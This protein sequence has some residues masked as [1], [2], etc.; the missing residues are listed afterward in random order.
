M[1]G[2]EFI[3]SAPAQRGEVT[4]KWALGRTLRYRAMRV[5]TPDGLNIA[6]QDWA[7]D[8]ARRKAE[9]LLLHGF[10]QSHG[11]WFHQVTGPLAREFR[12]VT[13]DLRGHGESDKPVDP[14]HYRT[15][16][17]WA[18]ELQAV[19]DAS[20]LQRPILVAWSYSGRVAL[21]YLSL[22][23]D[24]GLAGL[25][26]V[27]SSSNGDPAMMGPAASMLRQMTNLDSATAL[28]G[29]LALLRAC[30]T[31]PLLPDE[32]DYMLRYNQLVPP[33]IRINLAGRPAE[34]QTVLRAVRIPTLVMQG[35]LDPVTAPAMSAYTAEHVRDARAITYDG[36]AHM[37]FW[38]SPQRFDDDLAQF[39]NQRILRDRK[40]KQN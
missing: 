6:V 10:S 3:H 16:A 4:E 12:L 24:A 29:T 28:A 25:V 9:L 26:M 22:F 7:P 38:E 8:G 2:Y 23:G 17:L 14:H 39:V 36:L 33:A 19:I 27:N 5:A 11:A 31:K 21:D 13:Y 15:G 34:Y 20:A 32:L 30:V 35:S 37:P 40:T 1:A 18:R